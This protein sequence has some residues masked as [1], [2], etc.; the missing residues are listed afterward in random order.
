[1]IDLRPLI[2]PHFWLDLGPQAP[3]DRA[4]IA[5][6]ILL[7]VLIVAGILIRVLRRRVQDKLTRVLLRRSG[8]ACISVGAVALLWF[9]FH[10]EQ[11]RFFGARF[12]LFLIIVWA[13][14]WI[15]QLVRFVR[16][17]M[18]RMRAHQV[19]T[20]EHAKYHKK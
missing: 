6:F 1:M 9:F 3:S 2:T 15:V 19:E 13:A 14:V 16:H 20:K 4:S 10:Y 7:A 11:V 5:I 12:W 17:D 18:V 8:G